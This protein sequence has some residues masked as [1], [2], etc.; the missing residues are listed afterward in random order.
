M[1]ALAVRPTPARVEALSGARIA[2][3]HVAEHHAFVRVESGPAVALRVTPAR[4]T[5]APGV[6][7]SYP[8][9]RS[10]PSATTS[11]QPP[12]STSPS[13]TAR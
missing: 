5:V 9:T 13:P 6:L 4:T 12:G 11:A 2:G 7:V 10:T 8:F 1:A 3:L